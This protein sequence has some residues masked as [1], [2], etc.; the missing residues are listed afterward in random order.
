MIWSSQQEWS[1][2]YLV[3]NLHFS[4]QD[5]NENIKFKRW[6]WNLCGKNKDLFLEE[7]VL[8][9]FYLIKVKKSNPN[10]S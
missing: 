7:V 1:A 6:H 5:L 3:I 9:W 8:N 2:N 10:E 4:K